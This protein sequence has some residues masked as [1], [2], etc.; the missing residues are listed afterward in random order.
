MILQYSATQSL[1]SIVYCSSIS[2]FEG[3][4]LMSINALKGFEFSNIKVKNFTGASPQNPSQIEQFSVT[5]SFD[6]T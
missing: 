6:L 4:I 1:V 2:S 3:L 5:Q